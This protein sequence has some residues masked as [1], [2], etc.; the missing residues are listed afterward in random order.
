[1]ISILPLL[2]FVILNLLPLGFKNKKIFW[3]GAA[4]IFISY[5]RFLGLDGDFIRYQEYLTYISPFMYPE[6]LYYGVTHFL[7]I[8]FNSE[9]LTFLL[10]DFVCLWLIFRSSDSMPVHLKYLYLFVLV[11]SFWFVLGTQNVYRQFVA[12][13]FLLRAISLHEEKKALYFVVMAFF[14]HNASVFFAPLVF[15]SVIKS[16]KVKYL[17][18]FILFLGSFSFFLVYSLGL[19]E[20]LKSNIDTGFDLSMIYIAMILMFSVVLL[21]VKRRLVKG[22]FFVIYKILFPLSAMIPL[23]FTNGSTASERIFIYFVPIFIY[24][25]FYYCD[26][27]SIKNKFLPSCV[28]IIFCLPVLFF[29]STRGFL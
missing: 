9:Q 15:V 28:F 3:W 27:N 13:V 17:L 10:I 1:M 26:L 7:F 20:R 22:S 11:S 12:S 16:I 25:I 2:F 14:I 21:V 18:Y 6:F 4:I 23:S 24:Y 8:V 5:Q 29:P 19:V